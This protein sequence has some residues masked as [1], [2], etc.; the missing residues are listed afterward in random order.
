MAFDPPGNPHF[1]SAPPAAVPIDGFPGAP[2]LAFCP[3]PS[4]RTASDLVLLASHNG[5]ISNHD[6]PSLAGLR[7]LRLPKLL[8]SLPS[9]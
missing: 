6:I 9:H 4:V 8:K 1:P 5:W 2:V 3:P 7:S